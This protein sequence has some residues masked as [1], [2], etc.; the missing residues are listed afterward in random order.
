MPERFEG[1][2]LVVA[3]AYAFPADPIPGTVRPRL[4][5]KYLARLGYE[6]TVLTT[7][8]GDPSPAGPGVS[9]IEAGDLLASRLN[10]RRR[11]VDR[12]DR[13]DT[14]KP[15]VLSRVILPDPMIATWVPFAL[16]IA[17]RLARNEGID[18]VLTSS[19]PESVNVIGSELRRLGVPWVA[20]L[21]DGWRFEPHRDWPTSAQRRLDA[22][23]E[24]RLLRG[25]DRVVAVTDPIA[26]DLR[27]RLGLDAVTITNGYDP[28]ARAAE[29][30][31]LVR[32]D[33]RSVVYTGRLDR[34]RTALDGLLAAG[35][36]LIER[37]PGG[38]GSLEVVI[39]GP[40]TPEE[41]NELGDP[42]LG[43]LVRAVGALPRER[44]LALQ[45]EADCLL[46]LST[47]VRPSAASG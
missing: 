1:R 33:R 17:R 20:D 2:L 11:R 6:V 23:L 39:A 12:G 21:R 25:A 46:L 29:A 10:W 14:R 19:P 8:A 15:S 3:H 5:A 35:R 9:V 24:R 31:G 16:P 27:E 26:A 4:L 28:E 47:D 13:G 41:R 42:A 7:R 34:S 40:L 44:A 43:G 45:R 37:E 32:T 38:A 18:A 36:L 22:R 30:T